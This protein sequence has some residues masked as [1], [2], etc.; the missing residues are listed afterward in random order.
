M[1]DVQR[2]NLCFDVDGSYM[3][4]RVHGNY[5][6]SSDYDT[7]K[8]MFVN[9]KDT[10]GRLKEELRDEKNHRAFMEEEYI[11]K[12]RQQYD[13]AENAIAE[14]ERLGK[15]FDDLASAIGWTKERCEQSGDSPFDVAKELQ[16]EINEL[17]EKEKEFQT[18]DKMHSDLVSEYNSLLKKLK[19]AE[20]YIEHDLD[21]IN[22]V[23]RK[24]ENTG[25][26]LFNDL[27]PRGIILELWSAIKAV[28]ER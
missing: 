21:K 23:I 10:I 3:G 22:L 17:R 24:W 26:V 5:V 4:K 16:A 7:L 28:K 9:A 8:S 1:S 14:S 18:L 20:Q 11:I 2:F 12:H 6:L 19:V 27:P 25:R 13:R 15:L